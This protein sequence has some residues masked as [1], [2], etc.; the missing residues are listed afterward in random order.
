MELKEFISGERIQE[1]ANVTY[2]H[3]MNCNMPEQLKNTNTALRD[4]KDF[5]LQEN[6]NIVYVYGDDLDVFFSDTFPSIDK[7]IKII[8]HNTDYP[9]TQK[10]EKFLNDEKIVKWYAQNAI[11]EHEKLIPIPIGIANKQ[12]PHGNIQHFLQTIDKKHKK[13]NLV[14]KNFDIST[15][16]QDRV[17][18]NSITNANG[19][20]MDTKQSHEV[21]LERVAKSVFV[22]S[23][24]GNGIDCH[25]IWECL[26]LGAVPIV[27]KSS[28]FR[29]FND[30]PILF[31]DNW[32][33][34]TGDFLVKQIPNFYKDGWNLNKLKLSYW[35][36]LINE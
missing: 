10:Y 13:D 25:R 16:V 5:K 7:K 18:V 3:K 34:I 29:N 14:Y 24:R 6:E 27:Q 17:L 30:L 20:H 26:Y 1:I 9:V 21:Y 8:S 23:P 22:I 33:T 11:F 31:I 4:K 35:R 2:F 15:N 36:Q 28:A 32:E 12:W 19:I